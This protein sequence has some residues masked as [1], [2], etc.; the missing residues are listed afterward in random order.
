MKLWGGRFD[1]DIAG[2][3]I[4]FTSSIEI[5]SRLVLEDIWCNEAHVIMLAKQNIISNDDLRKILSSLERAKN[6]YINGK[7]W[8]KSELED[9]HTNI[10][11]YIADDI[12]EEYSGKLHTARSRNDQI[13]TDTKLYIR[14][15]I[16]RIQ[17]LV[18]GLQR[19]LL[20]LAEENSQVIILGYTHTQRAQPITFG[21]WATSY[22][23]MLTRDLDRLDHVYKITNTNPLGACAIAG[24]SF[25]IDRKLTSKL[26]GFDEIHEHSLD[27]VSSRD[28]ILEVLSEIAILMSTL[29]KISE[30]L[31]LWSTTEFNFIELDDSY[32]TGS[33]IMPQ[34]KNPDV[35][36][37]I[38][39]RTGRTYGGL[40]AVLTTVKGLP[41]G[42]NR[43]LQEDKKPLWSSIDIVKSSLDLLNG[44][45]RTMR[46]NKK[47]IS[48]TISKDFSTATELANY[49]VKKKKIPFRKSH[50]IVGKV[51]KELIRADKTL[52]DIDVVRK[53]L[54]KQN[55]EIS[56]KELKEILD[57]KKVVESYKSLG[58]T[59][60]REVI[61]MAGNFRK[62]INE[63][64]KIIQ[65]RKQNIENAKKLTSS[66][67]KSAM[68]GKS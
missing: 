10:E 42:Y 7:L 67:V 64:E 20:K 21:F 11:C 12:G 54:K 65:K 24:T 49:L 29:S 63:S 45:I 27:V 3:V 38:R 17:E 37:L 34:K 4:D 28:F 51:V 23:S 36:E 5:D 46:I 6:D 43:D 56:V 8:L 66:V 14:E 52:T 59:S 31:I 58:G 13:I 47:T 18:I 39:G 1:K 50:E 61:R 57:P 25:N 35:A 62:K 16:L 53:N 30:E 48:D 19:T 55:I 41:S 60:P 22:V 32:T 44:M 2:D 40:L 15:E 9:I 68:K 33:S 26:L